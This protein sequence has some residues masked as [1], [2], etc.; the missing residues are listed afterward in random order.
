MREEHPKL[1]G[2]PDVF[3]NRLGAPDHHAHL[4]SIVI[5]LPTDFEPYGHRARD[6]GGPDCSGGCRWF[7]SLECHPLDWGVCANPR[8]PRCGLLTF[9]HMGCEFFQPKTQE[10]ADGN[11]SSES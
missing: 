4:L 5:R 3:P 8:S 6:D 9:E 7:L 10:G 2:R 11:G 1:T